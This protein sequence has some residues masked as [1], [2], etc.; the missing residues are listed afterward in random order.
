[1]LAINQQVGADQMMLWGAGLQLRIRSQGRFG[2]ELA[3]SYLKASLADGKFERESLPFSFGLML[4]LFK[5]EDTRHFNLYGIA[6][7]GGM[8]SEVNLVTPLGSSATQSF[9]E[10]MAFGG[11]G[12]ELR[13]RWFAV[14]ADARVVGLWREDGLGDAVYYQGVDGGPVP[15]SSY[16]YQGKV[17]LNLWF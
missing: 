11:L 17:F 7:V 8:L 1:M 14:A 10:W 4:Y 5:N 12:A 2:L 15:K 16:G 13:F 3:N 9:F 6:G